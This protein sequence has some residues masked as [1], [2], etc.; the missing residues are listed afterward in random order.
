MKA[1]SHAKSAEKAMDEARYT[2]ERIG[3]A[4]DEYLRGHGW[5]YTSSTPGCFWMWV[6]VWKGE[7]WTYGSNDDALQAQAWME[8]MGDG[9]DTKQALDMAAL[10]LVEAFKAHRA[11]T[12][13]RGYNLFGEVPL[14]V[15]DGLRADADGVPSSGE[16]KP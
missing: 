10:A 1:I 5:T 4:V 3:F 13:S 9:D 15:G 8:Q 11:A 14:I 16:V 7:R 12:G 6:K 2:N